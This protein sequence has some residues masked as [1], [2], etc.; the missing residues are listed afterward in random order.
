MRSY[1]CDSLESETDLQI[2]LASS[3]LRFDQLSHIY[4]EKEI[5]GIMNDNKPD[6]VNTNV[7]MNFSKMRGENTS[8]N[9]YEHYQVYS[10]NN[11]A[12]DFVLVFDSACEPV[13]HRKSLFERQ[14]KI[15]YLVYIDC[16]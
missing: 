6:I 7:T 12:I 11:Q 3:E 13:P 9:F 15:I 4:P 16:A 8:S 1:A 5:Y 10:I 2:G 14:P